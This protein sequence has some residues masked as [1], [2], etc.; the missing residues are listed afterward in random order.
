MSIALGTAAVPSPTCFAG[1]VLTPIAPWSDEYLTG[2]AII[3]FQHK[4][5][6]ALVNQ[7]HCLI[8]WGRGADTIAAHLEEIL[9]CTTEHFAM[10]EERMA[11]LGYDHLEAHAKRH[12]AL[13][14]RIQSALDK[15]R[16]N[17]SQLP[18]D[19]SACLSDW[20]AHHIKGDDRRMMEFFRQAAEPQA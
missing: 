7:L 11:A 9:R 8:Q 10:E 18:A 1:L 2:D 13:Q 15:T 17:P 20:I 16:N 3:D 12:L 6:F 4:N 5:L 19:V 14:E